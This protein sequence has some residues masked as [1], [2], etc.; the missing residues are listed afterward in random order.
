MSHWNVNVK[1]MVIYR[2]DAIYYGVL[3]AYVSIVFPTFWKRIRFII[4]PL[5]IFL[6]LVLILF[7][8]MKGIFIESYPIFWNVWYF[9][10]N[11]IAILFTLPLLS[12]WQTCNAL[13]LKPI[14]YISIL[15]Y[16][17]YLL[18]Y[19]I[20]LQ[21][22]KYLIPTDDL[23]GLDIAVFILVY[24]LITGVLSYFVYRF[25]EKP[26]MDLRDLPVFRNHYKST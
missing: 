12:Q 9:V 8:P 17:I 3:G 5:G 25:Y 26:M 15:S 2:I 19:S 4:F 21:L 6:L 14:T 22:L 1:A 24:L 7:I 13:L 16:A 20:I 18:H 10:L 11:S 23:V